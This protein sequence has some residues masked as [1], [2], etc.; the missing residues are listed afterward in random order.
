MVLNKIKVMKPLFSTS[1]TQKTILITIGAILLSFFVGLLTVKFGIITFFASTIGTAGLIFV[2]A[3]LKDPRIGFLFYLIYCFLIAGIMKNFPFLPLG[4]FMEVI[5]GITWL[6]IFINAD[7]LKW[8]NLNNDYCIIVLI[9]FIINILEVLNPAGASL[10]GWLNEIRFTALNWLMVAPLAFLVFNSKK[11]LNTFLIAIIMASVF[12]ALYGVKQLHLG[13][14]SEEQRWLNEGADFTHIVFGELRVFSL[15]TD[16]GQFGA[17][18]AH[19]ALV[20]LVL[21]LGPFKL[22]KRILLGIAACILIYGMLISGTRGALFALVSGAFFAIFLTRN[23]K[24]LIV[25]TIMSLMFLSFLKYSTYG[26][27]YYEVRRLRTALDPKDASL[28]ARLMNQA[29]LKEALASLPFGG[30]V[31]I[32]GI[33]GDKYNAGKYLASIPPDSYWVKIWVMYGVVGLLIWFSFIMY[34]LGKSCGVVWN[35]KDKILKT[36]AIALA[37]GVA[38]LFFC[39][40]GN[41]VMNGMPSSII[42]YMSWSFIF[43]A[44]K[45]DNP[46][47]KENDYV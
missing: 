20:T 8:S 25:G 10:L 31:G 17:S 12:A 39:S 3:A 2:I 38:G 29:K 33:N 24:V 46:D 11:D 15:F 13:V 19:M 21:A 42:M 18:Q 27:E 35:I 14:S 7:K 22:W 26:N 40:Y 47:V 45:F 28:N 41:E 34:L 43:L 16:A 1:D 37:S 23:F 30:G 32:T 36:K 4:P 5:L 44:P 9:W 6:S